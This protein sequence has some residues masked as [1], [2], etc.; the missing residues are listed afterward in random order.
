MWPACATHFLPASRP[1]RLLA[2]GRR[3]RGTGRCE[4]R[5]CRTAGRRQNVQF[6]LPALGR[7]HGRRVGPRADCPA[8]R[9]LGRGVARVRP[10]LLPR[11]ICSPGWRAKSGARAWPAPRPPPRSTGDRNKRTLP[12]GSSRASIGPPPTTMARWLARPPRDRFGSTHCEF[13]AGRS[14]MRPSTRRSSTPCVA[15]LGHRRARNSRRAFQVISE[16]LG[17]DSQR[18]AYRRNL[19]LQP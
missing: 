17:V 11:S 12:N 19:G 16:R 18:A 1:W 8:R 10:T 14:I 4:S 13:P 9:P 6:R 2:D 3:R 7:P 5:F 15:K